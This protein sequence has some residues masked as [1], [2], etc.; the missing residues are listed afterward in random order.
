M[1]HQAGRRNATSDQLSLIRGLRYNR[2][3]KRHGGQIP[4]SSPQND[5]SIKTATVIAE[6]H[7]VSKATIERDGKFAEAVEALGMEDEVGAGKVVAPEAESLKRAA[8]TVNVY[9]RIAIGKEG[10]PQAI[11]DKLSLASVAPGY[12]MPQNADYGSCDK[13]S[14]QG[15]RQ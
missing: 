11:C 4:G 15:D 5:D 8:E 9:G 10:T 14:Q 3:Q 13:L 7:R 1:C 2:A 6:Q 12:A